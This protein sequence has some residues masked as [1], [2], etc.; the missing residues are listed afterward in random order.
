MVSRVEAG[1]KGKKRRGRESLSTAKVLGKEE[2]SRQKK[3]ILRDKE[4]LHVRRVRA[5]NSPLFHIAH[6]FAQSLINNDIAEITHKI[7]ALDVIRE[8]LERDLLKLQED[9]LELDDEREPAT[10]PIP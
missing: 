8:K 5:H 3:E 1:R 7:E 9:E 4:N 10:L 6:S 2:L